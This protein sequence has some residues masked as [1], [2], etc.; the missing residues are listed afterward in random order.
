MVWPYITFAMSPTN[1][2]ANWYQHY[3]FRVTFDLLA[4]SLINA[5]LL[6]YSHVSVGR[7]QFNSSLLLKS[8]AWRHYFI[9]NCKRLHFTTF[10]ELSAVFFCLH[11]AVFCVYFSDKASEVFIEC[12]I[13]FKV[14]SYTDWIYLLE[15]D[16]YFRPMLIFFFKMSLINFW[17][18]FERRFY[19]LFPPFI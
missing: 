6:V 14:K 11:D 17:G 3:N 1:L 9:T 7:L 19:F 4:A 13:C 12:D 15:L 10:S 2:I 8:C 5:V 18:W 16:W